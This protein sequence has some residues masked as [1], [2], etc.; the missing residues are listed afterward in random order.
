MRKLIKRLAFCPL[1]ILILWW[2]T[3]PASDPITPAE[4][5]KLLSEQMPR[6]F[7][8]KT[9]ER[10]TVKAIDLFEANFPSAPQIDFGEFPS[11][12]ALRLTSPGLR[13]RELAILLTGSTEDEVHGLLDILTKVN[14][15]RNDEPIKLRLMT[16]DKTTLNGVKIEKRFIQIALASPYLNTP[17]SFWLRDYVV[18]AFAEDGSRFFL[19]SNYKQSTLGTSK[20]LAKAFNGK[21]LKP[22][23]VDFR[24]SGNAGGNILVAPDN[25]L[26][27]GNTMTEEMRAYL[28]SFV[29]VK[30]V[31][32]LN[33]NWYYFGHLDTTVAIVPTGKSPCGYVFAVASAKLGMELLGGLATD[34]LKS[35]LI[36]VLERLFKYR[37]VCPEAFD[38]TD[39]VLGMKTFEQLALAYRQLHGFESER[40]KKIIASCEEAEKQLDIMVQELAKQSDVPIVR[41]P[42]L[43]TDGPYGLVADLT[44]A[45]ANM[46]ILDE[47]LIVPDGL[48]PA[49][50]T[51]TRKVFAQL[52]CKVHYLPSATFHNLRGQIHC[53]TITLR[54]LDQ[55][56]R[57]GKPL[58]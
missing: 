41:L 24:R 4:L 12:M 21:M 44:P 27:V 20:K 32:V 28:R 25:K 54:E 10:D 31:I 52:G 8:C 2:P 22:P 34:E 50:T 14:K 23:S 33:T 42:A 47:D 18:P 15:E 58:K 48:L 5:R 51:H 3:A 29:N 17:A 7:N 43:Y 6:I 49:F 11:S 55:D 37:K 40:G 30:E 56:V 36:A 26:L 38:K 53:A 39:A 9:I 57:G 1:I 16:N 46:V 35:E 45:L 13:P 19:A